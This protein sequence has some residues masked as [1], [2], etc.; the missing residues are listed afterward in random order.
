LRHMESSDAA[1][2]K[3]VRRVLAAL[4]SHGVA[5]IPRGCVLAQQPV[6]QA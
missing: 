5:L 2:A 4:G 6:G 3:A 1:T